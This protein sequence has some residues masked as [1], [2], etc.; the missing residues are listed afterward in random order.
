MAFGDIVVRVAADVQPY[1]LA[2]TESQKATQRN[3]QSIMKQAREQVRA[4]N[5]AKRAI[6]PNIA[7]HGELGRALKRGE[8]SH[9]EYAAAVERWR[10]RLASASQ[11][12]AMRT[13]RL[14]ASMTQ[15]S[16][17]IDDFA[18]STGN[19]GQRLRGVA[20][21][22][23]LL[24]ITALPGMAGV[25]TGVAL[26]LM[27]AFVGW[28]TKSGTAAE[29]AA[30]GVDRL[31]E[32]LSRARQAGEQLSQFRR[33]GSSSAQSEVERIQDE[34]A[35]LRAEEQ[36]ARRQ[37]ELARANQQ[38]AR[39]ARRRGTGLGVFFESGLEADAREEAATAARAAEEALV[40]RWRL[41]QELAAAKQR[42]AK[43]QQDETIAAAS[44]RWHEEQ[45]LKIERE[46]EALVQRRRREAAERQ[47]ERV[48]LGGLR[49][50]LTADTDPAA[51]RVNAINE[52]LAARLRLI[53]L[54]KS[55][56]SQERRRLEL[57]AR[58]AAATKL[59]EQ[60][61]GEG[62]AAGAASGFAAQT[63]GG[64]DTAAVAQALAAEDERRRQ[65][66]MEQQAK[67]LQ[68]S[69]RTPAELFKAE[70]ERLK[71]LRSRG[72]L[73][74]TTFTRAVVAAREE[75]VGDRGQRDAGG[76]RDDPLAAVTVD[77]GEAFRAAIR[78]QLQGA[79]RKPEE[80]TAK[81]TKQAADL[82]AG[83]Q[84]LLEN[85]PDRI[86]VEQVQSLL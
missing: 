54:A 28:L 9:R 60:E 66:E 39:G 12:S 36:E 83:I 2:M 58:I 64:E 72:L 82:L 52:E 73:D 33:G 46:R 71:E 35:G 22:L 67:S 50:D 86:T 17:A 42:A 27:P 74:D 13:R 65:A 68:A 51:T 32:S 3:T 7:M 8:I 18:N 38:A 40:N 48:A 21:N 44:A 23:Q 19:L 55:L 26:S 34:I 11:A 63:V 84:Q 6:P 25:L 1:K 5:E 70:L 10:S 76:L 59:A 69:L 30:K 41:E 37:A 15:A 75:F 43:A 14:T 4:M 31:T 79:G 24:A 56:N 77:S 62:L 61:R 45:R 49:R 53:E 29:K 20:N 47:Q 85:P 78:A 81:H 16:F 57:Q 80:D